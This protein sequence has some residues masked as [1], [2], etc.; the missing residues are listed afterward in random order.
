MPCFRVSAARVMFCGHVHVPALYSQDMA[1][2]VHG[3]DPPIG[4]A[5]PLLT[6]RRWL[7]V[8]GS[9]G[10]P[11]DGS[12][13]AAYAIHDTAANDLTFRR[14]AYDVAAT[15]AKIRAAGLPDSLAA[16]LSEG[17]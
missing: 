3:H 16:R 17:R 15:A 9:V 14:V 11:R 12:P 13:Q 10:Q 2:R 4:S 5:M 1:E 7:A 6:S 8:V